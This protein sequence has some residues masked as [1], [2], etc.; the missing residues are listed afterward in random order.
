MSPVCTTI[1]WAAR[2]T[3][4]QIGKPLAS[5]SGQRRTFLWQ[6]WRT[7]QFLMRDQGIRQFVDIGPGLPTQCNVHQLAR[8]HD[9]GAH[10]VYVDNDAVVLAHSRS[11]LHGVPGV[12]VI[13][14]DLREP[15]P[16][17]ADLQLR[18]LVD[19]AQPVALCMTLVLHFVPGKFP[20]ALTRHG[21]RPGAWR[22]YRY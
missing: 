16:I 6:L 4:W 5:C 18:E 1:T 20:G 8:Q 2:T 15:G 12:A 9:P 7:M 19:F 22:A 11:L 3:T 13:P 10:V 17:L 21:R 14:G